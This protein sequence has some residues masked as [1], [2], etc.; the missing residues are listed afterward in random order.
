MPMI[1][2]EVQIFISPRGPLRE[3]ACLVPR[4]LWAFEL[5]SGPLFLLGF[6]LTSCAWSP[7]GVRP[8]GAPLGCGRRRAGPRS[9]ESR[10]RREV[11]FLICARGPRG[12]PG[13]KKSTPKTAMDP[14]RS[15][16]TPKGIPSGPGEVLRASPLRQHL[17]FEP[18]PLP[19]GKPLALGSWVL[20]ATWLLL[21]AVCRV[22]A[23]ACANRQTLADLR[24]P[25]RTPCTGDSKSFW[26]CS[27]GGLS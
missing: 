5:A 14:K 24:P 21:A 9:T 23:C 10:E 8:A 20:P 16:C 3:S 13:S 6:V 19:L 2:C 26:S 25:N 15:R 7:S 27:Y 1:V 17:R 12:Y 18:P 4:A 22:C 11:S